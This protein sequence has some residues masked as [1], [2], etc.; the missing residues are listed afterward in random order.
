MLWMQ[1]NVGKLFV[2]IYEDYAIFLYSLREKNPFSELAE[3][4]SI[5]A[6]DN[7]RYMC[8]QL[9][10][11]YKLK[12]D[13]GRILNTDYLDEKE[14]FEGIIRDSE[15]RCLAKKNFDDSMPFT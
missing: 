13:D 11:T 9:L 6:E 5:N 7:L 12:S 3:P 15:N 8:R 14:I 2:R 4:L 10:D 1:G